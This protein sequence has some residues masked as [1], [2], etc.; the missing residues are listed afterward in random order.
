MWDI[1]GRAPSFTRQYNCC[2]THKTTHI[3]DTTAVMLCIVL[4]IV[5]E[6]SP[7]CPLNVYLLS[8]AKK[9]FCKNMTHAQFQTRDTGERR[10]IKKEMHVT[11]LI[12]LENAMETHLRRYWLSP[13]DVSMYPFVV[14]CQP[15]AERGCGSPAKPSSLLCIRRT[16]GRETKTRQIR[17]NP[18]YPPRLKKKTI[19]RKERKTPAPVVKAAQIYHLDGHHSV[20]DSAACLALS[21]CDHS[22]Q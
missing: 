2:D 19:T 4:V 10:K 13:L 15:C 5:A 17:L 1:R 12:S 8:R 6:L 3:I 7:W 14:S 18:I 16:S 20:Q 22:C 11:V 21:D 9:G